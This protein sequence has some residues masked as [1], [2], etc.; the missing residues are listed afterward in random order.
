MDL[1]EFKKTITKSDIKKIIVALFIFLFGVFIVWLIL[2][3]ADSEMDDVGTGGMVVLWVLGGLCLFIGAVLSWISFKSIAQVRSG[4]HPI[5][6]AIENGDKGHLVWIY[7][8]TASVQGGGKDH[9]VWAF[10]SNG[11][12]YALNVKAKRIQPIIKYLAAQFPQAAV[13]YTDEIATQ[14][15]SQYGIKK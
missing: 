8:F 15:K 5:V 14:M 11:K 6:A 12:H 13:G 7:Q 2:S 9:S 3:G 1:N 4:N 10:S